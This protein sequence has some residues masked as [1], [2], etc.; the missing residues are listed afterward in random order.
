MPRFELVLPI[1]ELQRLMVGVEDELLGN[2]VVPLFTPERSKE[3]IQ[4]KSQDRT[5]DIDLQSKP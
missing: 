2:E 4:E 3:E 5:L 1:Y